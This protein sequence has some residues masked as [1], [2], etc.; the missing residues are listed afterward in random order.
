[1]PHY[2][3]KYVLNDEIIYI[4]KTDTELMQRLKAHGVK[5][6]NIS[7]KAWD[8]LDKADIYYIK[9]ANAIMSDVVESELIRRYKPKYNSAKMSEW[10]G[11]PF[12][13]PE[14]KHIREY[15][16]KKSKTLDIK[17]RQESRR[18]NMKKH[19]DELYTQLESLLNVKTRIQNGDFTAESKEEWE[20]L[21]YSYDTPKS[22]GFSRV[23][24]GLIREKDGNMFYSTGNYLLAETIEEMEKDQRKAIKEIDR[25]LFGDTD[26]T[27][28]GVYGMIAILEKKL[29]KEEI[30]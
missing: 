19:L 24:F 6:D 2:C 17:S 23:C 10:S 20:N 12:V 8:D 3:Y 14:W 15:P 29:N 16:I 18:R 26:R 7:P 27:D 1:M 5:G 22:H 11:L 4:G 9:L 21:A 25:I 28:P 30:A 13:E